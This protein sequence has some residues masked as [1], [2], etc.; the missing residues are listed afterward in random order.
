MTDFPKLPRLKAD[1]ENMEKIHAAARKGQTDEVHRLIQSGIDPTIPNRFGCTALHLAC[2]FGQVDTAKYLAS[3]SDVQSAWHGQKP[4]HLAVLSNKLDLVSALV[5]GAKERGKPLESMLNDCDEMEVTQIGTHFKN[6][7]GQT[8]LHWCVGLEEAYLPMAQLLVQLGA[9]P[10]AKDKEGETPLMRAMEFGNTAALQLMLSSVSSPGALRWDYTD[11]A[12]RSHLHWAITY[13]YE[14]DALRFIEM[15]HDMNM[16]DQEQIVPLYLAIR[17]AMVRLTTVLL[18]EGDPFLV[19]NAPFHNGKVVLPD[20]ISW[21]NYVDSEEAKA[22]VISLLQHR[23]DEVTA[24]LDDGTTTKKK[25]TRGGSVKRM[26][27]APSAPVRARSKS[28]GR[29]SLAK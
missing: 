9:S 12:G 20:R 29:K 28:N 2:K 6:C 26:K 18:K 15:G 3:V 4:L 19:Q 25:K 13:N 7:S 24:S 8:A 14:D 11:K 5:D 16:A 22:S 21:L 10:T 27:L 23:L 17:G 1:D